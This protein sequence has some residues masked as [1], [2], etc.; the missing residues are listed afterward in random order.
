MLSAFFKK[1]S[2]ITGKFGEHTKVDG[3]PDANYYSVVS[4][5]EV[6]KEG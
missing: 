1:S 3:I 4:N 2:N 6:G 5:L